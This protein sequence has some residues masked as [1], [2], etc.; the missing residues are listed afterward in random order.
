MESLY[1]YVVHVCRYRLMCTCMKVHDALLLAMTYL[2]IF[3]LFRGACF[4]CKDG[5]KSA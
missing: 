5:V 1:T 2:V 3:L 4:A